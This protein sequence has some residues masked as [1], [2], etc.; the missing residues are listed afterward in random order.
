MENTLRKY[1]GVLSSLRICLVI[2][3]DK[4]QSGTS[5]HKTTTCRLYTFFLISQH[6]LK[7]S[8]LLPAIFH[9]FQ[10][11][12]CQSQNYFS[13]KTYLAK[14]FFSYKRADVVCT[15]HKVNCEWLKKRSSLVKCY[16]TLSPTQTFIG[17]FTMPDKGKPSTMA[18]T[19][20]IR[21][22][23]LQLQ[24]QCQFKDEGPK[25]MQSRKHAANEREKSKRMH[26]GAMQQHGGPVVSPAKR[27]C[28]C[29]PV[30]PLVYFCCKTC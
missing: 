18:Q 16:S 10:K 28:A 15:C 2:S 5:P 21:R 23:V 20:S 4:K 29:S 6:E 13:L 12:N 3:K 27:S 11:N 22:H 17:T 7:R 9:Y 24:K 14:I 26:S 30:L 25:K 19:I 1:T 8:Y